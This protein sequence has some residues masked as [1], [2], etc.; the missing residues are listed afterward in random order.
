MAGSVT[1]LLAFLFFAGL[2]LVW[3]FPDL[4]Q[5]LI[6]GFRWLAEVTGAIA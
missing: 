3:I 4:G 2:G 6:G 5:G 1:A